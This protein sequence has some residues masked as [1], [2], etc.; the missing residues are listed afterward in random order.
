MRNSM[1]SSVTTLRDETLTDSKYS[2]SAAST[3]YDMYRISSHI[4]LTGH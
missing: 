3:L 2:P 1:S 4:L